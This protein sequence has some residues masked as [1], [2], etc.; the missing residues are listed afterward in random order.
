[1]S[2]TANRTIDRRTFMRLSASAALMALLGGSL[3][4]CL[5]PRPQAAGMLPT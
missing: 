3:T 1:M 4:G 2:A 5:E